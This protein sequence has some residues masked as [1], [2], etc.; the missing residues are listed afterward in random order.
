MN[1][2][3]LIHNPGAGDEEHSRHDLTRLLTSK[4]F[5]CRYHSIKKEGWQQF[6]ANTDLVVIAGGDGTVKQVVTTLLEQEHTTPPPLAVLPMGTANNIA[7][8]LDVTGTPEEI[9]DSWNLQQT[10]FFDVGRLHGDAR[11]AYFTESFGY[12]VFPLLM[13]EMEQ[14]G[15]ME[16]EQKETRMR[17]A[18]K[19]LYNIVQDYTPRHC[20]LQVDGQ[21]HSGVFLLAE[22]MNTPSIGP[23]LFISPDSDPGDGM[24][25]VILI[26]GEHKAGFTNYIAGKLEGKEQDYRFPTIRAKDIRIKWKGTH[27]HVDDEILELPSEAEVHIQVREKALRFLRGKK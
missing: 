21:D 23:N 3:H 18:L 19:L 20:E 12:G 16:I 24:L 2:I 25:E 4:G 6:D 8:S 27:I 7:Q 17:E 5:H 11:P 15:K 10:V 26:T 1:N 9:I 14:Q 13:T 22:V